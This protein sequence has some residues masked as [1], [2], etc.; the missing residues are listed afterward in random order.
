MYNK[1]PVD[2]T[3]AAWLSEAL[4]SNHIATLCRNPDHDSNFYRQEHLKS[5]KCNES[6]K[7]F[8]CH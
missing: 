3:E 4:V 6:K 5:R 1:I 8:E 2:V 7:K